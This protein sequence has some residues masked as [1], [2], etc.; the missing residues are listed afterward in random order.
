M[1]AAISWVPGWVSSRA[2]GGPLVLGEPLYMPT[3]HWMITGS[4]GAVLSPEL[5]R[6]ASHSRLMRAGTGQP[7]F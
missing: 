4:G 2:S 6:V 5:G 1:E 3:H 7:C